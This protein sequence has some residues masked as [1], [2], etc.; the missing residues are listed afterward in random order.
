[1]GRNLKFGHSKIEKY[2]MNN[3]NVPIMNKVPGTVRYVERNVQKFLSADVE[4]T[5][6]EKLS[7]MPY[8]MYSLFMGQILKFEY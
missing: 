7:K 1:M 8:E 2:L 4:A 3:L 5:H 6:Q